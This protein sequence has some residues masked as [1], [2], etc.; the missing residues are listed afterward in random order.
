MKNVV[1]VKN[2]VTQ[3]FYLNGSL[4]KMK[5]GL[6][7]LYHLGNPPKILVWEKYNVSTKNV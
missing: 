4:A 7:F 2:G 6:Q 5:T 3:V 1:F